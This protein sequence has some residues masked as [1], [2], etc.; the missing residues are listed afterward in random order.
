MWPS[1][2]LLTAL[3][4]DA[5][6]RQE[7]SLPGLEQVRANADCRCIFVVLH[8]LRALGND[9]IVQRWRSAFRDMAFQKIIRRGTGVDLVGCSFC[10]SQG[11]PVV[12]P[13]AKLAANGTENKQAKEAIVRA[14]LGWFE[15]NG[16]AARAL[17]P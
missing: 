15:L 14:Q 5:D 4:V 10:A 9:L 6:R 2:Y 8:V 16:F 17:S 13:P 3:S 11:N 12:P 7:V 1:P